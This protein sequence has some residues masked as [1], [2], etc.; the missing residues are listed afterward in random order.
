MNINVRKTCER[1]I[2][3]IARIEKN[4]FTDP[5]SENALMSALKNE[6]E[7]FL[8]A[9]DENDMPAGYLVGSD[10][11]FCAYI[12]NIA[13]APETRRQGVGRALITAFI[14]GLS[15]KTVTV[16]LEVRVSNSAARGLYESMGF[17]AAG[18]RKGLYTA[19]AED[20]I[21]MIL[22]LEKE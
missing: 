15:E 20:G 16:S 5:W 9:A 22:K 17:K 8:T 18:V 2:P 19:P 14:N 7:I 4:S 11:G 3:A 21:V 10:D 13:A 1:D 6:F 12:D